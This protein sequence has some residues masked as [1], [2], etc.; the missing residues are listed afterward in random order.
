VRLLY[1]F[2]LFT[3]IPTALDLDR[4]LFAATVLMSGL[5]EFLRQVMVQCQVSNIDIPFNNFQSRNDLE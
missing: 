4:L 3:E 1:P 2:L 5:D